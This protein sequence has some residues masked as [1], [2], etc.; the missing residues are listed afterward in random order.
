MVFWMCV[1][2]IAG[3]RT[4]AM[5]YDRTVFVHPLSALS[6]RDP[7]AV[8][9]GLQKAMLRELSDLNDVMKRRGTEFATFI[10]PPK[11]TD[12]R[13]D[14]VIA[15]PALNREGIVPTSNSFALLLSTHGMLRCGVMCV[16]W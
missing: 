7:A 3:W 1:C 9:S 6:S 12:D 16:W 14:F 13:A 5:E 10:P 4:A 2:A 15:N 8:L 11:G